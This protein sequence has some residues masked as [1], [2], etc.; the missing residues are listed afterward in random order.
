MMN[1]ATFI[2]SQQSLTPKAEPEPT[3]PF[4]A[5]ETDPAEF[6]RLMQDNEHP[7]PKI[8]AGDESEREDAM[9]DGSSGEMG[10]L[11]M[12]LRPVELNAPQGLPK[13]AASVQAR[14][15]SE[16]PTEGRPAT[17]GRRS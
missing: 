10:G 5:A 13:Q 2:P 14:E 3:L 8:T 6:E 4:P 16:R 9:T 17:S 11:A 15:S 7:A 12:N 1:S